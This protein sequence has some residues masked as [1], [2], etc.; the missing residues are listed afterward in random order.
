M[1][2]GYLPE[3]P[4]LLRSSD[5]D[6][7]AFA[8][9]Q[10]VPA[11]GLSAKQFRDSNQLELGHLKTES[12]QD[13]ITSSTVTLAIFSP[14]FLRDGNND[15]GAEIALHHR[16]AGARFI[17]I[18][19]THDD[20][21][22]R[23]GALTGLDCTSPTAREQSFA[24]LRELLAR[25]CP[26]PSELP[27]PYP[28]LSSYRAEQSAAFAGRAHEVRT[29]ADELAPPDGIRELYLLGPSGSGKTSLLHAGL[30]PALR[31]RCGSA[32]DIAVV[33]PGAEPSQ[34]LTAALT[35]SAPHLLIVVDPLEEIFAA[36]ESEIRTFAAAL[37]QL[38]ASPSNQLL[39]ALRSDFRGKLRASPLASSFEQATRHELAPLGGKALREALRQP[40]ISEDVDLAPALL[41]RLLEDAAAQPGSLSLLQATLAELWPHREY[42]LLTLDSYLALAGPNASG[43]ASILERRA[44]RALHSLPD[45]LDRRV[46]RRVLL[47]LV[48][49]GEGRADTRRRQLLPELASGASAEDER[50]ERVVDHLAAHRILTVD[51]SALVARVDPTAPTSTR[52]I[53]LAHEA[54][55]DAWPELRTLLNEHR[56]DEL[57]RRHLEHLAQQWQSRAAVA[58]R[59]GLLAQAQLD[60]LDQWRTDN[61]LAVLGTTALTER[62]LEE[63][64]AAIEAARRERA[65]RDDELRRQ[66][67]RY[68]LD[69]AQSYLR[70]GRALRAFPLLQEARAHHAT[71]SAFHALF[72]WAKRGLPASFHRDRA[73]TAPLPS[74]APSLPA[75][76]LQHSHDAKYLAITNQHALRVISLHDNR[77]L[78][79]PPI[80]S[81]ITALAWAPHEPLLA[82][83]LEDG[84]ARIWN[85]AT[86]RVASPLL[87]HPAAITAIEWRDQGAT[88][89]T[90]AGHTFFWDARDPTSALLSSPPDPS[91]PS[92][93]AIL[94]A[95]N[96]TGRCIAAANGR[97]VAITS[98]DHPALPALDHKRDV[99]A[100]AWSPEGQRL[101]TACED[102]HVQIWDPFADYSLVP[103]LHARD[104]IVALT[105]SNDGTQLLAHFAN[106]AHQTWPTP[107]H[108]P[109]EEDWSDLARL[110]AALQS[111][112][113]AHI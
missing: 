98:E 52:A 27:C 31:Q 23:F 12:L 49:F 83:A 93:T 54:L 104:P 14:T 3:L 94:H 60:E 103:D 69:K 89:A 90:T 85:A 11:L 19:L 81:A 102:K 13:F 113:R 80:N 88:L 2:R 36:P 56:S 84:T 34:A 78:K 77:D 21:P 47:R 64:R 76:I 86:S 109:T 38:R 25:P 105:W 96:A 8:L 68:L 72:H 73:P 39:F 29:L 62:F 79:P 92:P 48:Q 74:P 26:A 70:G 110:H 100:L 61:S 10:L 50:L 32:L 101:A 7:E 107:H 45:E 63:S 30:L 53:D 42:N 99:I 20:I 15:L 33:R 55:I 17:P 6:D 57:R 1:N 66:L 59:D 111:V 71:G 97:R 4:L 16:R 51:H 24:Q 108:A 58:P 41:T 37:D 28:G 43:L 91:A 44:A 5:P 106:G 9:H 67:V 87:Q 112:P 46:A 95:T 22:A 65:Q 75:P 40:A 18:R 82:F 35:A